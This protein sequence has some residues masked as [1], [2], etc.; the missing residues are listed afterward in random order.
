M[1]GLCVVCFS[2]GQRQLMCLARALLHKTAVLILDEATAAV[3][4]QTDDLI[5]QTIRAEFSDCTILTIA[6]RL[7]TVMD[8]DRS[9]HYSPLNTFKYRQIV[10]LLNLIARSMACHT[11]C[12]FDTLLMP[13]MHFCVEHQY[14]QA[15]P[16]PIL[17]YFYLQDSG[18]GQRTGC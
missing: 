8:S 4:L 1:R 5:Q 14:V 6:H 7:N 15:G 2:V 9:V 13:E 11:S 12:S 18:T 10:S 3:D 17:W 16:K